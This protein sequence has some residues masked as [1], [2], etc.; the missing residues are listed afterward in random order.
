MWELK[1]EKTENGF[2]LSHKEEIDDNEVKIVKEVVE[3]VNDDEKEA[4]TKLLER[5]TEYFGIQYDKYAKDNL[6]IT[7]NKKGH[8]TE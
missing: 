3:E 5:V 2:I 6:E 8:S 1:I 4:M 7:W